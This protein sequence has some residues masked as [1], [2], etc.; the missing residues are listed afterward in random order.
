MRDRYMYVCVACMWDSQAGCVVML[1]F[2]MINSDHDM[3][4]EC[5]DSILYRC[6]LSGISSLSY[7]L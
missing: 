4:W 7:I 1:H 6:Q 3:M 5:S 2:M